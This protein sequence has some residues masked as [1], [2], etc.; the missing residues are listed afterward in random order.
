MLDLSLAWNVVSGTFAWNVVRLVGVLLGSYTGWDG[1]CDVA[2][3]CAGVEVI[4]TGLLVGCCRNVTSWAT[5]KL[6]NDGEYYKTRD[7]SY[8]FHEEKSLPFRGKGELLA[9]G[10]L[11]RLTL[12]FLHTAG[13]VTHQSALGIGVKK[14]WKC[15]IIAL[16]ISRRN[17][18]EN[19]DL[20]SGELCLLY[21]LSS[22]SAHENNRCQSSGGSGISSSLLFTRTNILARSR[23][24]GL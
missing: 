7:V 15:E 10:K 17:I 8:K 3:G 5:L 19:N 6:Q 23:S 18:C 11:S 16:V 12:S 21:L 9:R 4:W 13:Y 1:G 2:I 14:N 20:T 24:T 22:R